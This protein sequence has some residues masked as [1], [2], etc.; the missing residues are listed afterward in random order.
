MN[1]ISKGPP[2]DLAPKPKVHPPVRLP[3]AVHARQFVI[4]IVKRVFICFVLFVFLLKGGCSVKNEGNI[5][6]NILNSYSSDIPKISNGTPS[7][8]QDTPTEELRPKSAKIG[9]LARVRITRWKPGATV[10]GE[11]VGAGIVTANFSVTLINFGE[12]AAENVKVEWEIEDNGNKITNPDD[13]LDTIKKPRWQPF[14][15]AALKGHR[16]FLYGPHIGA[17][18]WGTLRLRLILAYTDKVTSQAIREE[19]DFFTDYRLDEVGD[20]KQYILSP[21]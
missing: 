6:F 2:F 15:L 18:G 17:R 16:T 14:D 12:Y 19:H 4:I 20:S 1:Q 13:W 21:A 9:V 10:Y 11:V 3:L 7:I 8:Q 5:V